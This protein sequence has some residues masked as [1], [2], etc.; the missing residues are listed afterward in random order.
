M[1][2]ADC[3]PRRPGDVVRDAKSS[4]LVPL[5]GWIARRFVGQDDACVIDGLISRDPEGGAAWGECDS[6]S[7]LARDLSGR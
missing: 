4:I 7:L 3:L 5:P 2:D 6:G 1:A